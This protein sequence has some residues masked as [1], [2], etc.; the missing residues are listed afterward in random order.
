MRP[1]KNGLESQ[2]GSE[3]VSELKRRD[4]E[5]AGCKRDAQVL[6]VKLIRVSTWVG[7]ESAYQKRGK[8]VKVSGPKSMY[9]KKNKARFCWVAGGPYD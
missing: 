1:S 5:I 6:Q 3:G 2:E 7:R 8:G 9:R 4:S